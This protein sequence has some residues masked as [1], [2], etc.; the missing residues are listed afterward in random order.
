[1]NYRTR[2]VL[3]LFPV[4][5]MIIL[6]ACRE[7]GKTT[8]ND[9]DNVK[10]PTQAD[11]HSGTDLKSLLQ[12]AAANGDKLNDS[13]LLGY[14]K[15][16]DSLYETGGYNPIWSARQ[17]W[18]PAGDSLLTFIEGAQTYGLF[19][20]DYH[21]GPL[22]FFRRI[23]RE[24]TLARKNAAIWNRAD[25]LLTDAFFTLVKDL[26][27]GRLDYDSVTLRKDSVLPDSFYVRT[28]A[29]A[30]QF[31]VRG[32]LDSL[33]PRIPGYDS[34]KAYLP[35]FLANAHFRKLTWLDYP[36]KDSTVFYTALTRRLQEVGY[37]DSSV[38]RADTA[39]LAAALRRYQET[40]KLKVTGRA[41]QETVTMM[42]NSDWEKFKRIAIN[43]DRYK[44]LPDTLPKTYVW[45]DLP[46]FYLQVH[47]ADT[48]AL[49]SKVI[50]GAPK[51]R[52]PLLTSEISNFVT[53]PQWTVPNS[54]IFKEML[55]AIKRNV[56]Y[57]RKQN[58]M[59]V[60][61]NDSV[62]DPLTINWKRL[63]KNN[64]PYQLKQRQ[65][66]DNSLGVMKFNFKNKYDVY[67]H[68]TNVRWMFDNKFRAVSHGCV[69]VQQWRKLSAF[70]IRNDTMRYHPDTLKN[71]IVRQEK[72]TVWGFAH[73][74]I[75]LRYFTAE[76][77]KGKIAFYDDIYGEDRVARNKYFA[78]KPIF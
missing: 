52:T 62:R 73:V 12:Y 65:G 20:S 47:D 28:L 60:D 10:T 69:R 71:W 58:L 4:F 19:P 29:T 72:H 27:H 66:D 18:L 22:S 25:I 78:S 77:K 49:E 67:L 63:S 48:I 43:L 75:Y 61:D 37:I 16:V 21:F 14:R 1:M 56:D 7:G 68:D 40:N 3:F 38:T 35:E 41:S 46:G 15:L 55:P 36:F 53:Y 59:V 34:L 11:E 26:R 2:S 76:G 64:F 57:L 23:V 31:G 5:S 54:I 24:D 39:M 8:G 51:T 50:V 45:V 32:A 13:T 30:R 33:E 17:R 44:L 9:K 70:L 74:P 6:M 42:N